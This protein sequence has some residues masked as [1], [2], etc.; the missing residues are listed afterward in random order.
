M[1]WNELCWQNRACEHIPKRS[2][3][4]FFVRTATR[5]LE[6][7]PADTPTPLF[8]NKLSKINNKS[9]LLGMASVQT[10]MA[11]SQKLLFHNVLH[12]I[13][14]KVRSQKYKIHK[15]IIHQTNMHKK[16]NAKSHSNAYAN[17]HTNAQKQMITNKRARAATHNQKHANTCTRTHA[18]KQTHTNKHK[19]KHTQPKHTQT[20]KRNKTCTNNHALTNAQHK[21]TTTHRQT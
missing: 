5:R 18:R 8:F 14:V 17:A 19:H 21:Q 4:L 1:I 6:N 2:Q 3:E 10:H 15:Y 13:E 11:T 12:G 7:S 16:I 20:N 9:A